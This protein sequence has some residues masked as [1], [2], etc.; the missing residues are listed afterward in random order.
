MEFLTFPIIII[1]IIFLVK[2]FRVIP[3][4]YKGLVL[5]LGK[6]SRT[7][8]PGLNIVFIPLETVSVVDIR[9]QVMDI[10]TQEAITGDN[11]SCMVDG[12]VRFKVVDASVAIF[13]VQNFTNQISAKAQTA[14]RDVIGSI[15]LDEILSKRAQIA[16]HIKSIVDEAAGQWGVDILAIEIQNIEIPA[17]MKRAMAQQA[18]AERDKKARIIKAEGERDAAV[19]LTEAAHILSGAKGALELRTLQTLKE[20]SADP[21]EKIIMTLPNTFFEVFGGKK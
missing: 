14:L 17:D 1:V 10:P 20:I 4:G 8:E 9:E 7:I 12:I 18:E 3:E 21:S 13:K 5:F 2:F 16:E 11:V 6:Y 15:T 19:K